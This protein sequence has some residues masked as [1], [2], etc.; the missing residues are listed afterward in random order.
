M[1]ANLNGNLADNDGNI[2]NDNN[3]INEN[4]KLI[5]NNFTANN[6]SLNEPFFFVFVP[7]KLDV[8]FL[9]GCSL[10]CGVKFIS[11]I[12]LF[13]SVIGIISSVMNEIMFDTVVS[14]VCSI[15]CLVSGIYLFKSSFT[16]NYLD[17]KVAYF[18]YA[19]LTIYDIITFLIE[20][21]L[22][23]IGIM[24]PFGD[25]S[26]SLENFIIFLIG[27]LVTE[28]VKIYLVWIVFCYMAHIHLNRTK[29]VLLMK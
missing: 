21:L 17:A 22:I 12:F 27:G 26:F 29:L 16:F 3:N 15:F 20:C 11:A 9:C 10:H 14:F 28:I 23:S 24:N 19:I 6:N 7:E 5:Q 25:N 18:I 8:D 4:N 2:N 1:S 13:G